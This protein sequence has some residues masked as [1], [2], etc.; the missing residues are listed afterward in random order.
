MINEKLIFSLKLLKDPIK[1]NIVPTKEIVIPI[2]WLNK[3]LYF[4]INKIVKITDQIVLVKLIKKGTSNLIKLKTYTFKKFAW[5]SINV[6]I[7]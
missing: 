6:I 4:L 3:Y 5:L 1:E 2:L 7:I